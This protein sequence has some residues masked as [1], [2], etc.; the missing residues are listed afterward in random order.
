MTA[1][2]VRS[3]AERVP[4]EHE[5]T[6]RVVRTLVFAVPPG[7]VVAAGWLAWG[8]TLHWHD[9]VVLA[10]TYTL[11]GLGV[12]VGYHRRLCAR[13]FSRP[14]SDALGRSQAGIERGRREPDGRRD[15]AGPCDVRAP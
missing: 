2:A 12:T 1:T 13:S 15:A 6:D 3:T 9:L 14:G 4:I 8:G 10:I 11:T 5:S 7:A